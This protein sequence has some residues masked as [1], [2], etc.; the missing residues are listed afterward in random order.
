MTTTQPVDRMTTLPGGS[1]LQ[2]SDYGGEHTGMPL[3]LVCG[4]TQSHR[5]WAPLLPALSARHRVIT[6][7][8]RG[9]G[10]STRGGGSISGVPGTA[11]RRSPRSASRSPRSCWTRRSS[12]R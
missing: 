5:L 11:T 2:I 4:T 8:H 1:A 9:I 10:D 6:Y 12:R 3:V 7:D